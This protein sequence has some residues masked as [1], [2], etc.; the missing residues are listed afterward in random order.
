[1][2]GKGYGGR[3][4]YLDTVNCLPHVKFERKNWEYYTWYEMLTPF[5]IPTNPAGTPAGVTIAVVGRFSNGLGSM[6]GLQNER[7]FA[8]GNGMDDNTLTVGW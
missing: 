3:F 6:Y 7:I 8:C 1:M 2:Q 4:P 5:T